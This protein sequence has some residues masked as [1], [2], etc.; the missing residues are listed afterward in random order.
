MKSAAVLMM[1]ADGAGALRMWKD[2]H[3]T[4]N[5]A[6]TYNF[7][8]GNPPQFIGH[9]VKFSVG[10]ETLEADIPVTDPERP[11]GSKMKTDHADFPDIEKLKAYLRQN[12]EADSLK[13]D[14]VKLEKKIRDLS[15]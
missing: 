10:D 13:K 3:L 5:P 7:N 8:M 15:Y 12:K 1:L 14:I 4:A 6:S 2:L 11:G 9:L